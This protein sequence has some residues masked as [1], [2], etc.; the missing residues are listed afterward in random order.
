MLSSSPLPVLAR[1]FLIRHAHS[2]GNPGGAQPLLSGTT[3]V[4]LSPRGREELRRLQRRLDGTPPFAAVYSSPLQRALE[5]ARALCEI[6][7]GPLHV[8]RDLR[9]I[10]CGEVDGMPLQELAAR[11]PGVWAANLRQDDDAFRWPDGESY[12]EFR[13]RCL[14]AV[15][16][17]ARRHRGERVALVTHAGVISQVLGALAGT[18]AARWS[19]CRPGNASIS[20]IAWGYGTGSVVAF[21]HHAALAPAIGEGR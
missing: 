10:H 9:E 21:D 7:L 8:C 6:G 17:I 19:P 13:C 20:E 15:R 14:R 4:P 11:H 12:R 2:A 3:D 1:L 5:T 18:S 16:A